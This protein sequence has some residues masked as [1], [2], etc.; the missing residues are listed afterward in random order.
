[1]KKER[2]FQHIPL[3]VK[4]LRYLC[5]E[6]SDND[7]AVFIKALTKSCEKVK[8]FPID[9]E[10]TEL[11]FFYKHFCKTK[12]QPLFDKYHKVCE[13]RAQ[14]GASGGKAKAANRESNTSENQS[15]YTLPTKT[16]FRN[17]AKSISKDYELDYDQYK[18]DTLFED[19]K[20]NYTDIVS[21]NKNLEV[22][23]FGVLNGCLWSATSYLKAAKDTKEKFEY[24]G[25]EDYADFE[26]YISEND[27]LNF[28]E[29]LDSYFQY[30][31]EEE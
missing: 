22:L 1:M 8:V 15:G 31:S 9:T 27:D 5:D 21:S 16:D 23:V 6:F 2:T 19:I 3:D 17:L 11:I 28:K 12:L 30:E 29:A 10:D 13:E 26:E 14:A 4:E 18:I 25:A 20:E 7:I 24:Y